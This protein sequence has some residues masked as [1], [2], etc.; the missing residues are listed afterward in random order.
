VKDA[1]PKTKHSI[2]SIIKEM[3]N[4]ELKKKKIDSGQIVVEVM[5]SRN[6]AQD[7][8]SSPKQA[9]QASIMSL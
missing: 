8:C 4:L 5:S 6:S 9:N 7:S 2:N 3:K 1:T